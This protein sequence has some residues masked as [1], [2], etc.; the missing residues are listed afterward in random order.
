M[1]GTIFFAQHDWGASSWATRF[2]LEY[3]ASRVADASTKEMLIEL[4]E[5]HILMLDVSDPQQA[6][7][8]DIIADELPSHVAHLE[9]P[10]LRKILWNSTLFEE[11]YRYAREQQDY[12][13]DP[14]QDIYFTIGPNP[15]RYFHLKSLMVSVA[16]HLKRADYVRID[17]SDYTPE[18]RAMV[19]DA[20][21]ELGDPRVLIV[22]DD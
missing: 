16:L 4:V 11:L 13:R 1:G 3:L 14:A 22:G 2:V 17:V 9:D 6:S 15:S 20:V 21:A 12:N 18:Q 5:N 19:R 7:L 8:V 10:E